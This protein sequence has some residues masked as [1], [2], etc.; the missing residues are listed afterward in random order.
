MR[1]CNLVVLAICGSYT[2]FV[3][4]YVILDKRILLSVNWLILKDLSYYL[5]VIHK[6]GVFT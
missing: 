2:K 6:H 4:M 1:K 5:S 3:L